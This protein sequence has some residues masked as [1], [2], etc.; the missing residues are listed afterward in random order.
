MDHLAYYELR[1][2]PFSIVPLTNFYYHNEQHDQAYLRLRR[3]VEGMK[4]LAVL[5]GEVGTGKTLLARRLLESLPDD[6]YEA[7]LLVVLH[8]S[9][10]GSWL[11]KRVAQQVGVTDTEGDKVD[12]IGRLYGRLN[13]IAEEGR[14][15]V[16]LI[17]EAHMLRSPETLE[18]V[19]GLLN[20]ELSNSKL[21]SIVMFG[22]PELDMRL[23]SEPALKQRM[24]VRFQ[25]KNFTRETLVDYVRF[26]TFH[27]GSN[28]QIFSASA[29]EA[30]YDFTR[31]NPRLVNV[32]C[33]N[34]LFEGFV[35]RVDL[36][37]GREVVES[38]AADLGLPPMDPADEPAERR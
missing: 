33:D 37:V 8:S 32:V 31:G 34:S 36:P 12:V 4:G 16:I 18:E 5:V 26:R 19:R 9:V 30:I 15:A 22:M 11:I 38:V 27:A 6:Q 29:L 1:E 14:R 10:T 21:L 3:S 25:L 2:E 7:A 35:R 13:E 24:A 28:K 20:L 23:A 17:D